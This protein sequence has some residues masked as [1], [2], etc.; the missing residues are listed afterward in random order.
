LRAWFGLVSATVLAAACV[1]E[2]EPAADSADIDIDACFA[3]IAAG[4]E[5][6]AAACP[7]FLMQTAVDASQ[8][9]RDVGGIVG[10]IEAADIWSIDVN[11]DDR[12]EHAFAIDDVVYCEGAASVFSCGSLGCP[13][14]LYGERDGAWQFIG[15]LSARSR[16]EIALADT[17][18]EDG[19]HDLILGCST[20]DECVR[21]TYI[22]S[23]GTYEPESAEV[24][25]HLVDYASSVHGLFALAADTTVLAT[26]TADG[27]PLDRYAVGTE[28]AIIGT[29]GEYYYVSPCNACQSGFVAA[30][31]IPGAR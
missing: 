22:W 2:R 13:K 18:R 1:A 10:A 8:I 29:A 16:E 24:R 17:V 27:E 9:C 7:S 19:Y 6:D 20:G 26:P 3:A 21:W 30:A 28:V 14:A 12:P 4:D 31:L 11:G 5:A 23:N 15:S 25:G